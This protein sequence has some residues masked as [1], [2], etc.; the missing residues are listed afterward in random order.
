M[1]R[2]LCLLLLLMP[3]LAC[4]SALREDPLLR[5]SSAEA[6]DLGK[7]FLDQKKYN[8]AREHFQH[9]FEVE[10]NSRGGREALLL[11]ADTL[12]TQG[13]KVRMAEAEGKYRDYLTRFPTS[14]RAAYVQYRIGASLIAQLG[15]VDRDQAPT[16]K[17]IE[18]FEEL[19]RLYPTSDHVPEAETRIV[20]LRSRLASHEFE[21]GAFYMRYG[22][23]VAA[24]GRFQEIVDSYPDFPEMDKVLLNLGKAKV[25]I[26]KVD[27]ALIAFER[28][29][30]EHP[31]SPLVREIPSLTAGEVKS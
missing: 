11:V 7:Q 17:A 3:T 12:Y 19:I 30:A 10:P 16:R 26:G 4:K 5:L 2:T 22:L 1:I 27:E 18:A 24:A 9:A 28:L 13:G 6:L 15:R 20:E 8:K 23:P 31:E 25:R 14:D 29:R 21:I